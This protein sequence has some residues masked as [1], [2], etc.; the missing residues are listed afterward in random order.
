M[1]SFLTSTAV[2]AFDTKIL[3]FEIVVFVPIGADVDYEIKEYLIKKVRYIWLEQMMLWKWI[4]SN[5]KSL[6]NHTN[7]DF[8]AQQE[9]CF[10]G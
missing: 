5:I 8:F 10:S 6:L 4:F 1:I 2:P 9:P 3:P 7:F